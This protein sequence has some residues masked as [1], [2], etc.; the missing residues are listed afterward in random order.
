MF[1]VDPATILDNRLDSPPIAIIGPATVHFRHRAVMENG[2]D[3]G[4]LEISIDG[5]P[6]A[7]ILTAGGSFVSG[8]YTGTI[9]T[10]FSSPIAGRPAW[11]GTIGTTTAYVTVVANL[12]ATAAGKTV[13]LRWRM[14]SDNAVASQGW[15]IDNVSV[16]DS[17]PCPPYPFA[18]F[19]PPISNTSVN[20]A[21][22]GSTVPVKFSLGGNQGM[23][24]LDALSPSSQQVDCTTLVALGTE[25]ATAS[26][27]GSR[28]TYDPASD[29]YQYNWKTNK[30]WA[31]TC[32]V[33][34]LKLLDQTDHTAL[35][36]FK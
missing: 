9:S 18:G 1:T 24:I 19:F 26:P 16:I 25:E 5:G 36:K 22:A 12:P 20:K 2:F 11:T 34:H 32:R 14:G 27:G 35:F 21:N 8:G 29:R 23:A 7:D 31:G 4:V 30:A 6:F 10:A 15:R 33:L 3:G 13:V 28:L 17:V